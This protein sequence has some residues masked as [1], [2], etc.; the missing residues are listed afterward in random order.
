MPG[1]S[2]VIVAFQSGDALLR[3]VASLEEDLEVI[4]VDNGRDVGEL[5]GVE[6][7]RPD[8]NV[9]F[10][11]GCNLGAR[12]ARGDVLVFL[13]PDTVVGP[14]AISM[15]VQTLEDPSVGVAMARLRLLA[16]PQLLNSCGNVIHVTGLA[17]SG[18]YGQPAVDV[19]EAREVTYASGAAMAMR[20]DVFRDLGGFREELFLYHED[21][22]LG[23]RA[24]MRGYR[25]VLVPGADVFHDYSYSRNA[26]KSY[27]LERNRLVFLLSAF[28]ARLLLVLAPVLLA[29]EVALCAQAAREGWLRAKLAGWLWCARNGRRIL[30]MRR[31]TQAGR[32]V[33]DREL[34]PLLTAIVDPGMV[35]VSRAVRI[36]NP[37]VAGYWS[38]ARRAL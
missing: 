11:A 6:V 17:W 12:H 20:A 24:R 13:N 37:L 8:E 28:S 25:V 23:W 14:G 27:Y 36:A 35:P 3:C 7:V 10:A 16:D 9:G 18:G 31:E 22:D 21:L 38:L 2:V 34:A 29:A 15:L 5:A 4:V 26:E 1:V 32:R 19:A 33:P 30:G